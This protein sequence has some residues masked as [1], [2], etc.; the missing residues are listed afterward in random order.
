[1]CEMVGELLSF[2]GDDFTEHVLERLIKNLSI[3]LL[4]RLLQNGVEPDAMDDCK[5]C[6]ALLKNWLGLESNGL[7]VNFKLS[8]FLILWK[9]K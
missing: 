8:R 5:V 7:N 1:M 9:G 3:E 4:K 2:G 6:Q